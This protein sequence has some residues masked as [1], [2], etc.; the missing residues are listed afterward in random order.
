MSA[1]TQK[2][3]QEAA[4]YIKDKFPVAPEIGLILGSGLGVLADLITDGISI[5]Y[6]E[7][8]HFPVSTVEG[9]EGELLIGM[10]E[11]RRVVMMKGRFHMYEGYGPEVTAFPVRVMK[12]LGIASLLVTNAAGG[13]NTDFAPGDLMLLTDHLNMTGRNP[14]IGPNDPALGVRFPDMSSAYSR[15]LIQVAK[16]TAA[17]QNFEFKEGVYAGLL[18]PCYETPAEIVMLRTL[19]ADA[20]GM[21]TVSETIVARHAGIEVLGISC[22]TNMAAGILDQPLNHEEVMETAERVRERF[23][24][25][26]L[27]FIPKM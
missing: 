5:P 25:L 2:E 4:I 17:E 15:R 26:V 22:I 27:G 7:I 1:L 9:H 18:G 23:L 12:E 13:V 19:G 8:P 24:K 20:V 16:E 21:S 10:I 6:D 11:G 3:I 14:L